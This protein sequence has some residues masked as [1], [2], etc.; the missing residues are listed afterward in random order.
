MPFSYFLL[1]RVIVC[2]FETPLYFSVKDLFEQNPYIMY[3]SC[4]STT[5]NVGLAC[6]KVTVNVHDLAIYCA[7][8]LFRQWKYSISKYF[9][10]FYY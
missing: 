7:Q 10:S 2:K 3:W 1:V 6:R 4:L 5:L 8:K 9:L